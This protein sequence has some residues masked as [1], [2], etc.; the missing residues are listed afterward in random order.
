MKTASLLLI[1]FLYGCVS[2]EVNLKRLKSRAPFIFHY[3]SIT[4]PLG[5]N[6]SGNDRCYTMAVDRFEN[7]YCAGTTDGNLAD[8]NPTPGTTDIFIMKYNRHGELV[9]VR[10]FGSSHTGGSASGSEVCVT[11]RVD[12]DGNFYCGGTTTGSFAANFGGGARDLLVMKISPSGE[13]LWTFQHDFGAT[14]ESCDSL[15]V[16]SAGRVYCGGTLNSSL[17]A[18][19]MELNQRTGV[20]VG[21][22][23]SPY[24]GTTCDGIISDTSGNLYCAGTTTGNI[25]GEILIGSSD[26]FIWKLN[27]SLITLS[28]THYGTSYNWTADAQFLRDIEIDRFGYLYIGGRTSNNTVADIN[29]GN[30]ADIL[31]LKINSQTMGVSWYQQITS[32][33]LNRPGFD[34]S[35]DEACRKIELDEAS[36]VYCTSRTTGNLADINPFAGTADIFLTKIS[37]SGSHL[38][39]VQ[40]GMNMEAVTGGDYS[41]TE[42]IFHLSVDTNGNVY[43]AGYTNGAFAESNQGE[44]MLLLRLPKSQSVQGIR[45]N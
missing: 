40:F 38:S 27:S 18:Y 21:L 15:E 3:G 14:D 36:N 17:Q 2:D 11:S 13:L 33:D 35:G 28:E 32:A 31:V 4:R 25:G 30:T 22:N 1:F 10:Q 26:S 24:T 29:I 43:M 12:N 37:P 8:T 45:I 23:L 41:G 9:W 16:T 7:I 5:I 39:T 20:F 42:Q 34:T 19:V 44:D 6:T